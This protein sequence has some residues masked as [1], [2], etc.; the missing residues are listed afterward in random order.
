MLGAQTLLPNSALI[1]PPMY[2]PT[3]ASCILLH[4]LPTPLTVLPGPIF[5]KF[6]EELSQL[7]TR[8]CF[9]PDIAKDCGPS[10]TV[11]S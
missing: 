3:A 7:S 1:L 9:P 6:F 8:A 4:T 10:S 2:I 5:E 11:A